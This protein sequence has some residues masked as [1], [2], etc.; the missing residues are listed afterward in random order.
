MEDSKLSRQS[1]E[2]DRG[3]PAAI[4]PARVAHC[5]PD[6]VV[7]DFSDANQ[8]EVSQEED[9]QKKN[10]EEEGLKEEGNEQ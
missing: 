9:S 6:L 7:I 2:G 3:I 4:H 8:K 10:F 1:T 5:S